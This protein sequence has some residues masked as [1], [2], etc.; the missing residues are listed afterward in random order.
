MSNIK[1]VMS[2]GMK[3]NSKL[4]IKCLIK[5]YNSSIKNMRKAMN[6]SFLT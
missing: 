4:Q 3:M 6:Q 2:N 1:M 5:Q